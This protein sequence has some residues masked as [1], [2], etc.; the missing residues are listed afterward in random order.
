MSRGL[1]KRQ[2]NMLERVQAYAHRDGF[3]SQIMTW[4][5]RRSV[6]ALV[7]KGLCEWRTIAPGTLGEH[8][9]AFNTERGS[10]IA[11]RFCDA[12]V[13]E[14]MA[15]Q[16]WNVMSWAN[17]AGD[18][19]RAATVGD[20]YA[21]TRKALQIIGRDYCGPAFD[22]ALAAAIDSDEEPDWKALYW[23]HENRARWRIE[24]V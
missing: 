19:R 24:G 4:H 21:A 22:D 2:I 23:T 9:A 14:A 12:T 15:A 16:L 13:F 10:T 18:S 1:S 8:E 7:R 20:G 3:A 5:E 6:D 11:V 17:M